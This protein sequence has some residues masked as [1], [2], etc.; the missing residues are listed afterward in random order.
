MNN[1]MNN[2]KILE[3]L[4]NIIK[5]AKDNILQAEEN[6]VAEH[7]YIFENGTEF[8][9]ASCLRIFSDVAKQKNKNLKKL[10]EAEEFIE[11]FLF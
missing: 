7:K 8:E 3:D 11:T 6:F 9:Q 1:A 5:I 4:K 10:R 2:A